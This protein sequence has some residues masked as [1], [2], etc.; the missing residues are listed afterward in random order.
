M[1][2]TLVFAIPNSLKERKLLSQSFDGFRMPARPHGRC[3]D[4]GK[5]EQEEEKE[6]GKGDKPIENPQDEPY[7]CSGSLDLRQRV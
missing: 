5:I 4:Y 6:R 2:K 1:M 7:K 3:L